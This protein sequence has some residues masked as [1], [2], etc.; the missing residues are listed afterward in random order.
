[1]TGPAAV[2]VRFSN[3]TAAPLSIWLEPWVDEFE[4]PPRSELALH[5]T[6]SQS[7]V[8]E[9][10]DL[11]FSDRLV[12]VYGPRGS[13]MHVEIDGVGQDSCSATIPAPD[14]GSLSTRSF[15]DILFGD[16]PEARPGGVPAVPPK[17]R[18]WFSR[19]FGR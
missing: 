3:A 17:R 7:Q 11:E 4:L 18:G 2:S 10:P 9:W 15:V 13:L 19:W 16:F 1:M 12:T 8:P 6:V 5:V 14:M